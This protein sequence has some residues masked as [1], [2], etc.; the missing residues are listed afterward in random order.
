LQH[1]LQRTLD[2]FSFFGAKPH[3][4]GFPKWIA[5]GRFASRW[6][7]AIYLCSRE[8]GAVLKFNP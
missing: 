8:E 2:I 6:Q 7:K 3:L 4:L 1:S 5:W